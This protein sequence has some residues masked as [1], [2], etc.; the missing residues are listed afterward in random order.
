LIAGCARTAFFF[1]AP[2]FLDLFFSLDW[3]SV[4]MLTRILVLRITEGKRETDS[5][6]IHTVRKERKKK[7][8]IKIMS[9]DIYSVM[10]APFRITK[11]KCIDTKP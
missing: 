8:G 2:H 3:V 5:I 4:Y 11:S 10:P 6:D 9:T 1:F 7:I